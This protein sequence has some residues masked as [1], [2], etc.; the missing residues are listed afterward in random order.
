MVERTRL[1]DLCTAETLEKQGGSHTIPFHPTTNPT[2]LT[3]FVRFLLAAS[4]VTFQGIFHSEDMGLE[5]FGGEQTLKFQ[6]G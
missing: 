4:A 6:G 5:V 2:K 3:I 1:E